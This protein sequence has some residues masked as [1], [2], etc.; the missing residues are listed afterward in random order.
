[1]SHYHFRI[2]VVL[3]LASLLLFGSSQALAVNEPSIPLPLEK[4]AVLASGFN[5]TTTAGGNFTYVGTNHTVTICDADANTALNLVGDDTVN[6]NVHQFP[7]GTTVNGGATDP[8]LVLGLI[9]TVGPIVLNETSLGC[10]TGTF[11]NTG[12]PGLVPNRQIVFSYA[13]TTPALPPPPTQF[14]IFKL[15]TVGTTDSITVPA[16]AALGTNITITITDLDRN[17]IAG[18]NNDTPLNL[19]L[20]NFTDSPGNPIVITVPESGGGGVFSI[21][22]PNNDPRFDDTGGV[23]PGVGDTIQLWYDPPFKSNAV[24]VIPADR[25]LRNH[26]ITGV[27][28][29]L[30]VAVSSPS[31]GAG[32]TFHGAGH[33]LTVVDADANL[34]SG[35]GNDNVTVQIIQPN[36]PTDNLC[37]AT[38]TLTE[39]ATAGTFTNAAP[40]IIANSAGAPANC[41]WLVGADYRVNGEAGS[42]IRFRY[43]DFDTL[44]ATVNRDTTLNIVSVATTLTVAPL[45]AGT[46]AAVTLTLQDIDRNFTAGA[47]NNTAG[48]LRVGINRPA[49]AYVT[50]VANRVLIPL[51]ETGQGVFTGSLPTNL[52]NDTVQ[53]ARAGDTLEFFYEDP[54]DGTGLVNQLLLPAPNT[55]NGT[56]R[57][58][59]SNGTVTVAPDPVG[60]TSIITVTV[61]DPDLNLSTVAADFYLPGSNLLEVFSQPPAG[62]PTSQG[63]IGF[64]ETGPN[65]GIFRGTFELPNL[66]IGTLVFARYYDGQVPSGAGVPPVTRNSNTVTVQAQLASLNVPD[67]YQLNAIAPLIIRITDSDENATAGPVNDDLDAAPALPTVLSITK[68]TNCTGACTQDI[69]DPQPA[70]YNGFVA[71]NEV[72][73]S[74]FERQF[75]FAQLD[76]ITWG[77]PDNAIVVGDRFRVT[78]FDAV[79]ISGATTP[80]TREFVIVG[81]QNAVL[82]ATPTLVNLGGL[83]AVTL[84]DADRNLT[85]GGG[86]DS[87]TVTFRNQTKLTPIKNLTLFET[88]TPGVFRNEFAS[89]NATWEL[90]P[91]LNDI[92]RFTYIDPQPIPAGTNTFTDDV[93]IVQLGNTAS[94]TVTNTIPGRPIEITVTDL[95]MTSQSS[96]TIKAVNLNTGEAENSITLTQIDSTTGVF[97]GLLNTSFGVASDGASDNVM[98][99]KGGDVVRFTYVDAINL[100]G[101][102]VTLTA[103][104]NVVDRRTTVQFCDRGTQI[105]NPTWRG[106]YFNNK[107]VEGTPVVVVDEVH[108]SVNWEETAPFRQINADGWSARWTTTIQV[109]Q[110]G[111]FRFRLGADDGIR[112]WVDDRLVL[113]QFGNGS[114]RTFFS[115]VSL[116]PGAHR[117]RIEYFED[118]GGAGILADCQFIEAPVAA[119][120]TEGNTVDVFPSDVNLTE[121]TAHIT[122]GRINVR[123]NPDVN[124]PR[125]AYVFIYERYPIRG[126]TDDG[127]WFLIQL[128]DGR[129][130]WVSSQFVNRY[131]ETPVQIYPSNSGSSAALPNVEVAAYALVEINIRDIPRGDNV[132]AVLPQG[133]AFRVLSRTSSGAW[134][135]ISFEGTEGWVLNLPEYIGFTNG[136][137]QDLPR[138]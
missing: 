26:V 135:K 29:T 85:A 63:F 7:T 50:A 88:S 25:I 131:E 119:I 43:R 71:A 133:A 6:I 70:P 17:L 56:H 113:D 13:D 66:A 90:N 92:I 42:Q 79:N 109:T 136:T 44:G 31:A 35:P 38:V 33:T 18:A 28:A 77:A 124:A 94:I 84:T 10:F 137:V 68:L 112:F 130:G 138:E 64:T 20:V 21:T 47:G 76:A 32:T 86:N 65:T 105:S 45:E 97:R 37:T 114:F 121:A 49:P 60:P 73:A 74:I 22:I 127:Q 30:N 111:K 24:T 11:L 54:I 23:I 115:D 55:A 80:I 59:A 78:Y 93:R 2:C 36:N 16:T 129:T 40:Y 118:A 39:T 95:D 100:T 34:N 81:A 123:A 117:I 15:F 120:D 52:I 41:D 89:S 19:N 61:T 103:D 83:I 58:I 53:T 122:T 99:V 27:N 62:V 101:A 4:A 107:T 104:S 3:V 72:E 67:Q 132:I 5:A 116:A 110:N 91:S 134:I 126:V 14:V 87:V 69:A 128:K 75:T 9:N 8:A 51:T 106:E 48:V 108:L 46:G 98:N 102:A 12:L 57:I 125:I 96:I 82:D 1:M